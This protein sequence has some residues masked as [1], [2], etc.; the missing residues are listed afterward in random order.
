V[1]SII[2]ADTDELRRI[3]DRQRRPHGIEHE[4]GRGGRVRCCGFGVGKRAGTCR[5]EALE[6]L[7]QR[8]VGNAKVDHGF[9]LDKAEHRAPAP[10]KHHQLHRVSPG[11]PLL[12]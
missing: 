7:G 6:I 3:G 8:R 10:L 2:E 12:V 9:S 5:D 11:R 1:Q 4:S